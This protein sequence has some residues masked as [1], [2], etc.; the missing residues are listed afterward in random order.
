MEIISENEITDSL[1]CSHLP[2]AQFIRGEILT[3]TADETVQSAARRMS[4]SMCSSIIV[5]EDGLPAGIWTERDAMALDLLAPDVC[6]RPLSMVMSSPVQH[7]SAT[8]SMHEVASLMLEAGLRHLLVVDDNGRAM[9]VVTQSDVVLSQGIEHYLRLRSVDTALKEQALFLPHHYSLNQAIARMRE[10]ASEA[11]LI[12]YS[13]EEYGI[14]TERDIVRLIA[15]GRLTLTVGEA[16]SRPLICVDTDCTLYTARSLL[17][18]KRLRHMGVRDEQGRLKGLL[19]FGD[20]L[21]GVERMYVQELRRALAERDQALRL[22]QRNLHLAEKVIESSLEGVMITNARGLIESVNPSFTRLTGYA[23]EEVIGKSPAVLASGRHDQAF[24]AQMWE[25]IHAHGYWQGEVWNR[26]KCGQIYPEQLT[27]TAI[28]DEHGEVSHYAALFSDITELKETEQRIRSLAYYDPLT[29]LPNRRL[30]ADRLNVA[31]AHAHRH[32]G[33]LAVMFVDLDRFKRINDS[34]GHAVGDEILEEVSRRLVHAVRDDDTVAR[35]G[36]DEFI[37]LLGEIEDVDGVAA[38]ARR[39]TASMLEP[40]R[41]GE[42]ELVISCSVGISIYPDD[43][44]SA[45]D[46]IQNADTAMYRAKEAGRNSFQLYSPA[47]NTR[48]LEHLSLEVFLRRALDNRELMVY[49]QPLVRADDGRVVSAEALLRWEH[50]QMGWISPA[51]FIPLAEEL[52]LIIQIDEFVLEQ[53]F[54]YLQGWQQRVGVETSISVNIS[55][56]HFRHPDF[57][58]NLRLQIERF[59]IRSQQLVLELTESMLVDDA[60]ENIRTM[61]GLRELGV[62]LAIDD[63]GTGYSSLSYLRRFPVTSLKIDRSFVRGLEQNNEDAAIVQAVIQLAHSLGLMVVAE[64]VENIE[65]LEILREFGCELIQGFYYSPAVTL[66][67]FEQEW[68]F[69]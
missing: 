13:D 63:F 32:H 21:N 64:G 56:D 50:P 35:I 3:A 7:V 38:V 4:E 31:I 51:D 62:R 12:R 47:M 25:Q 40:V 60:I 42:Q 65:Q 5:I 43:G 58:N 26:R 61:H 55:A 69:R 14:L 34:L 30:F 57:L 48:S 41:A 46:L 8:S 67:E 24:Y 37:V 53:V 20:I 39:M 52:G 15:N 33:N 23:P 28:R 27:I 1:V 11:A 66:H 49:L 36:G 9:G 10:T 16:A 19:S 2:V 6:A 22:S 17:V 44:N 18:E 54:T 59:G 29:N 45:D 68:L